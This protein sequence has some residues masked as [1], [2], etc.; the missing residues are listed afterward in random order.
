MKKTTIIL[1]LAIQNYIICKV[2][3]NRRLKELLYGTGNREKVL[4]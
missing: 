1:E 3:D 4:S 2:D